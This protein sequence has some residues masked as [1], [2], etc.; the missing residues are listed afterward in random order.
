MNEEEDEAE[1]EEGEDDDKLD[2]ES[3]FQGVA[4]VVDETR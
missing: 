4:E 2:F 1:G 3:S